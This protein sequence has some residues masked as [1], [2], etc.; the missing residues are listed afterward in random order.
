MTLP[1]SELMPIRESP[2]K[3]EDP[4]CPDSESGAPVRGLVSVI[5]PVYNAERFIAEAIDSVL[6]QT[7][8][9]WEL[10]LVDD[11]SP[12]E[13]GRIARQYA[14]RHPDRIKV[15]THPGGV[16]RGAAASRNLGIAAVRGEFMAFLDADDVWI[17]SKL[18]RQ[19]AIIQSRQDIGMVYG[20]SRYWYAWTGRASD[21][22]RDRIPRLPPPVNV[23]IEPPVLVTRSYPLG[24]GITPCP[25]DLLLRS[26]VVRRVGGFEESFTGALQLYEDQAFL[27][28]I[29]LV[30][31]TV[32]ADE[33]WTLYRIHDDSC[34]S[35]V[36]RNGPDYHA[37][38]RHYLEWFESYLRRTEQLNGSTQRALRSAWIQYRHPYLYQAKEF[39][40]TFPGR[41]WKSFKL[42]V[43]RVLPA[44][45]RTRLEHWWSRESRIPRG[46]VR[47]GRFARL[48]PLSRRFGA[49]RGLPLDRYYIE[50]FLAEHAADIRGRALEVGNDG[51]L[52]RF[53]GSS[54]THVD[55]LDVEAGNPKAT[56]VGDASR[57]GTLPRE[58]FDC[59]LLTQTLQFIYDL[60]AAV[61][62]FHAALKPG[63]VLLVT[64]PGISHFG[65]GKW[66]HSWYWNL[67]PPAAV[68]L[69]GDVFG[70][71]AVQVIQ[72]G[73]VRVAS[74][75]LYG[76]SA[77]ELTPGELAYRDD[78]YP[79]LICTR[80]VRE[81]SK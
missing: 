69:L 38:R 60:P 70:P 16:N 57:P 15:L 47:G 23:P 45:I 77:E 26:D 37:V 21:A 81:A 49:D 72:Y 11:A 74:A 4:S 48:S 24:R 46:W 19:T 78:D 30:A 14:E 51:Y 62:E 67:A 52:R 75:F 6:A 1:P 58:T 33:C 18:E 50:N 41:S 39:A 8:N 80:A 40:T 36:G 28:K 65:R 10:L 17:P 5:V 61:R 22:E 56:I 53:G 44:R 3:A 9:S 34:V 68:R 29:H 35:K 71:G 76:L 64:A 13:S 7:Y 25:S 73:N 31:T 2:L 59:I 20:R 79:M 66:A 63:G 43:R 55:V 42:A 12:D 32:A 27:S 54:V